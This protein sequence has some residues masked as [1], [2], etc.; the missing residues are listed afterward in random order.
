MLNS[1]MPAEHHDLARRRHVHRRA[2]HRVEH[3]EL[4]GLHLPDRH[5]R[6]R[7][8]AD[9]RVLLDPA[10]AD[11]PDAQPPDE[12]V[13]AHVGDLQLQRARRWLRPAA[14]ARRMALEERL[15][16]LVRERIGLDRRRLAVDGRGVDDR[17]V[18]LLVRRA[19]LA[20]QVERLVD[21]V[22]GPRRRLVDLV[23]HHEHLET[24][25]RAPS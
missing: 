25:R 3:E 14:A 16:V 8:E 23:D 13:R 1:G 22:L 24:Q 11:A 4:R 21:D 6:A 19:Q 17:E 5:A 18:R 9:G 15:H 20:E 2:P 12:G 10:R 7:A